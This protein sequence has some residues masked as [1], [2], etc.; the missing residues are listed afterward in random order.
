MQWGIDRY[1]FSWSHPDLFTRTERDLKRWYPV[2]HN[3][4]PE[5]H[6]S[7]H[8][9]QAS[10]Y[11]NCLYNVI[12]CPIILS[13]KDLRPFLNSKSLHHSIIPPYNWAKSTKKSTRCGMSGIKCLNNINFSILGLKIRQASSALQAAEAAAYLIA[14]N[15]QPPHIIQASSS[16]RCL[17]LLSA[18][19]NF[20]FD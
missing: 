8:L 10:Y 6:S 11:I 17:L 3:P 14:L 1:V 4:L 19:L 20:S 13:I 18:L 7:Q 5:K 9:Y 16:S 2:R 12:I 15:Q